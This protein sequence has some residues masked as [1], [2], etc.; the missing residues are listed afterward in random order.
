MLSNCRA[1]LDQY[2]RKLPAH[3]LVSHYGSQVVSPASYAAALA[4]IESDLDDAA[5]RYWR[6]QFLARSRVNLENGER[7]AALA[8]SWLEKNNASFTPHATNR[9]EVMPHSST[10]LGSFIAYINS[11]RYL[12]TKF[13]YDLL[14]LRN[15]D[16]GGL[17]QG[18]TVYLSRGAIE[19]MYPTQLEIHEVVHRIVD[20]YRELGLCTPYDVTLYRGKEGLPLAPPFHKALSMEESLTWLHSSVAEY[21]TVRR[22]ILD[23]PDDA[24]LS[25]KIWSYWS[26]FQRTL[27]TRK[28]LT[29][30]SLKYLTDL[31]RRLSE[32][33]FSPGM[34]VLFT[35]KKTRDRITV[36][37]YTHDDDPL[38]IV[39]EVRP[40]G[41]IFLGEVA[42]NRD[43]AVYE[44]IV[45]R[46]PDFYL[47][48]WEQNR[49]LAQI[50]ISGRDIGEE[51]IL[52]PLRA[53]LSLERGR[54]EREQSLR[55]HS[56]MI[57]TGITMRDVRD[58]LLAL[59][60]ELYGYRDFMDG[61]L[62][63]R[64]EFPMPDMNKLLD[65]LQPNYSHRR[66]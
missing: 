35:M 5:T 3:S 66:N 9:L 26:S 64:E 31:E 19:T 10:P 50:P 8:Q 47:H 40:D 14:E 2:L 1:V 48:L 36:Q 13:M 54:E 59:E 57:P 24:V 17:Y 44:M 56:A 65:F 23:A 11:F 43:S 18:R 30:F 21:Q 29:S 6:I 37:F 16:A 4:A 58:R 41:T 46:S 61:F 22:L 60:D 25:P 28:N 32:H 51:L 27:E 15:Q 49:S 12:H 53:A 63:A 42:E 45:R 20:A 52:E 33:G 39:V 7:A 55:V 34:D 62:P 38:P